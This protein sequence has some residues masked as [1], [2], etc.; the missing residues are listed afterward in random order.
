M[1]TSNLLF[2]LY[3]PALTLDW[4]VIY[5]VSVFTLGY[6]SIFPNVQFSNEW[7]KFRLFFEIYVRFFSVMTL[8]IL[9]VTIE[10]KFD[11]VIDTGFCS[12]GCIQ[13]A[14]EHEHWAATFRSISVNVNCCCHNFSIKF[15]NLS[16]NCSDEGIILF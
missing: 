4:F 10:K 2:N 7:K 11:D 14:A 3:F 12:F 15:S 5:K 6:S 13:V 16:N 8:I 1:A 9:L